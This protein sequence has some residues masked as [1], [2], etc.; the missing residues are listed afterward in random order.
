M[1]LDFENETQMTDRIDHMLTRLRESPVD[2]PLDRLESAVWARIDKQ[3]RSDVFG[4]GSWQ[5]QLAV[6]A[7]A[8]LLGVFVAQLAGVPM[9]PEPLNS[10]VIVL[11]DDSAVA[12]SV[13]LEG[14]I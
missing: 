7:G 9:M 14:G 5:I 11:S 10:E 1:R 4:G 13:L 3:R 12:P 2:E 6:T 8:L